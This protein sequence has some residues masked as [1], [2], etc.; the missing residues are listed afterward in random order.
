[1][2]PGDERLPAAA[3]EVLQDLDR[4]RLTPRGGG[5]C[6]GSGVA[7]CFGYCASNGSGRAG[8]RAA[9]WREA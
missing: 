1:M 2:L 4:R 7:R 9:A 5:G 6:S 8:A 3:V